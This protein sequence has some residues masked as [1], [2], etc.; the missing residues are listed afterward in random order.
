MARMKPVK[1]AILGLG[2]IGWNHHLRHIQGRKDYQ[3][4]AVADPLAARRAEAAA[5]LKCETYATP[6][7]LLKNS[8]AELVIVATR[9]KDH[10]K[11]TLACLKAG[12]HV[13]VEKP[14]AMSLGQ[15]DAMME[16]ARRKRRVLTVHQ[17]NRFSD[18]TLYLK[19][20][21]AS[22]IIGRVFEIKITGH[23]FSL[24]NDWQTLKKNG[25]GHLFNHGTH[26]IDAAL[27]LM[28]S[29]VVEIWG[30]MKHL[31]AAGDADDYFKAVIRTQDGCLA[32]VE[33]SM[34][35]NY[36]HEQMVIMGTQ[37]TITVGKAIT[38]RSF[39]PT[40]A[41][42]RKRASDVAP[43]D[44]CYGHV[45]AQIQWQEKVVETVPPQGAD[46][47]GNIAAAIRKGTKLL[48]TP[49]SVREQLRVLFAIRAISARHK[50]AL[51]RG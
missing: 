23:S 41:M 49:E 10:S 6:A 15:M 38:I 45:V 31:V 51:Y 4:V 24:R 18:R 25:G 1:T 37:G 36:P 35:A 9:S 20:L 29:P 19:S 50:G 27:F 14:A 13:L 48:I 30:D 47:Y 8:D 34:A 43:A 42:A 26:W 40:K 33:M 12:K 7:A 44:R 17:N 2:R 11:H 46:F 5:E 28:A 22:G 21:L 32:D 16:L 39:K 3:V